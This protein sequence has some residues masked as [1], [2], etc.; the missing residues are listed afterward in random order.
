MTEL[1]RIEE[2]ELLRLVTLAVRRADKEF[3]EGGGSSRHWVRD[4]F[5]PCIRM[6]G[7]EIVK[8]NS[9]PVLDIPEWTQDNLV[10]I[11]IWLDIE[12]FMLE[13]KALG[14]D[15]ELAKAAVQE[16]MQNQS[17]HYKE[18]MRQVKETI[19]TLGFI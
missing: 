2:T 5:L 8:D 3:E 11:N 9:S 12:Q 4:H 7:L 14:K 18:A 10:L 6:Q 16:L 17:L 19:V 13:I 15:P 1:E